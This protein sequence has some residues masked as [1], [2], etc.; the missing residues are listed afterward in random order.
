MHY[1]EQEERAIEQARRFVGPDHATAT[2]RTWLERAERARQELAEILSKMMRAEPQ[3][4]TM[5][6]FGRQSPTQ[7][8][9]AA[10]R[11]RS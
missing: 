6:T 9:G 4:L 10:G 5:L 3:I 1:I 2:A 7:A 11:Q 8:A